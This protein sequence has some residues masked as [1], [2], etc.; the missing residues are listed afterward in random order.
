MSEIFPPRTSEEEVYAKSVFLSVFDSSDDE[1]VYR[2][3]WKKVKR[4]TPLLKVV[5]FIRMVAVCNTLAFKCPEKDS[6]IDLFVIVKDG[7]IFTART[8]STLLFHLLGIRRH[9]NKIA[10][11]FCLSFYLS[12]RDMNLGDMMLKPYDV[13]MYYWM[14]TLKPVFGHEKYGQFCKSNNLEGIIKKDKWS[15]LRI[16]GRIQ[17]MILGGHVGEYLEKRLKKIHL[18][19]HEKTKKSLTEEASVVVNSRMLKYHNKDKRKYINEE[20]M[21]RYNNNS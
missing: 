13:Y 12:D 16:I 14:R 10:K 2:Q 17:E 4:F 11:R 9:S 7:R 5:P 8:I 20:F 21:R 6:D 1:G 3:Y 18:K 15:F 19:R